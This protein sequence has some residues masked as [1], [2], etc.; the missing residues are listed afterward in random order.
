[1]KELS[2]ISRSIATYLLQYLEKHQQFGFK[3]CYGESFTLLLLQQQGLLNNSLLNKLLASFDL[4]DQT[5]IQ[6]HFEFNNYALATFLAKDANEEIKQRLFP[7]KFKHLPVTNWTLLRSNVRLMLGVDKL[8]ALREVKEKITKYQLKSGL[9]L[10]DKGVKSFQYHCFSMAMVAEIYE[11]TKDDFHRKSFLKGV[12]FIRNFILPNGDTLYIGRGQQQSFG[13]AALV[14]ILCTYYKFT[15]DTTV[16]SDLKNVITFLNSFKN[17]NGSFPLVMNHYQTEKPADVNLQDVSFSGWY[18]YNNYFD[19]LPF[20]G[21]FISKA[22]DVLSKL[23]IDFEG[24]RSQQ[25]SYSDVNFKKVVTKNYIAVLSKPGGYWSN[26]LPMP[27]IY[28]KGESVT[29]CYGGEQYEPSINSIKAIPLPFFNKFNKSI[30]WRCVSFWVRNT[31]FVINPL[32]IMIRK[33][34]FNIDTIDVETNIYSIF[35]TLQYILQKKEVGNK[36]EFK[37]SQPLIMENQT[38]ISANGELLGSYTKGRNQKLK[39]VLK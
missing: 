12:A 33:F 34:K 9:I 13:Y 36:C 2:E 32:G 6:Y 39:I 4:L 25:K 24:S 11:M 8:D 27:Y 10:D 28:Y 1:M 16:L 22:S 38:M 7:L 3:S 29:P 23:D 30:R 15:K 18:A 19:Y 5:S 17:D 35:N 26:D 20:M 21:V 14:Y 31:L 37:T